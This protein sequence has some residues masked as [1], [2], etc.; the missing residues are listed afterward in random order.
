MEIRRNSSGYA[1][2]ACTFVD[3]SNVQGAAY[4]S[5]D[6]AGKGFLVITCIKNA[7]SIQVVAGGQTRTTSKRLGTIR[8]TASVYV[9]GKGDGT[10][11]FPGVMDYVRIQIG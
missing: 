11:F 6:L 10:D 7:T 5:V 8:N 1:T 3:S 4:G 2:A 9:G